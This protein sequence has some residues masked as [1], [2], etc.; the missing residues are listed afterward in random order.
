MISETS[1]HPILEQQR[2]FFQSGKTKSLSFRISQLKLLQQSVKENET[3]I[4]QAL[5]ADLNKPEFE[6]FSS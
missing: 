4:C 1:I 2:V 3:V 6:A 5:K